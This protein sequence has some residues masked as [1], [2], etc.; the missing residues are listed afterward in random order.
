[1]SHF[2][3]GDEL[4]MVTML[5][6]ITREVSR[7]IER[8]ELTYVQRE[9]V[10][11]ETAVRQQADYR[12]LLAGLG[13]EVFNLETSDALPDC[14][15]VAD[16][17][18]VLDELAV[19][20]NMG[21]PSRRGETRAVE[22]ILKT[23]REIFRIEPPATLDGGDVVCLGKQIFVG[24]SSRTNL[25]GIEALARIVRPYGYSVE[26]VGVEGSLH[27][28]T[29]CSALDD[30][31]MLVNPCWIDAAPFARFRVYNV[32][33]QEPWA[34]NALRIG[35]TLFVEAHAP[36]TLELIG[37]HYA[38]ARTLDISEFR[39]AEGSLSCLSIIFRDVSE[40]PTHQNKEDTHAK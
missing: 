34:A 40:S 24:H 32:P 2:A 1:M 19:I 23:Q 4:G 8:C 27:L 38:D 28:T 33:E 39:K 31:T 37:R 5:K 30:E 20:P 22:E 13:V 3:S 7:L 35:E 14:C 10:D 26:P 6:A 21:A 12:A 16:T 11:Y 36:R 9:C 17:A 18:V 15:F 29:G 25:E